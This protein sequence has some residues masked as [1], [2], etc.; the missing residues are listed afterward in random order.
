MLVCLFVTIWLHG[1]AAPGDPPQ[2]V[3]F[4]IGDGVGFEQV[5]AADMY[6]NG[7]EGTLSFESMPYQAEITTYST[8]SWVRMI[9]TR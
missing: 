5:R 4:L 6:L 2:N 3:I 9:W 1:S 8:N 7:V